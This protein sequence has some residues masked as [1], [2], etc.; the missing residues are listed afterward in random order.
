V[1][2][3]IVVVGA[4]RT[5]RELLQEAFAALDPTKVLGLVFNGDDR[6]PRSYYGYYA[7][8][9]EGGRLSNARQ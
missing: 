3:F 7:S 9:A 1:E 4:H 5:R 6:P 8:H 2:G